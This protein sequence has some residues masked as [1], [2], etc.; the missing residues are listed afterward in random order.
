MARRGGARAV[1]LGALAAAGVAAAQLGLA[2]GLGIL[3]WVSQ[4]KGQAAA[5]GAWTAGLA[6]ATWL[7]ATSVV[8]GAVIGDRVRGSVENGPIVRAARRIIMALA[9]GLGAVLA[10]PLVAVP[11]SKLP[12]NDNYAPHLLVGIYV[13]SGV[14]LGLVVALFAMASRAIAAN[15]FATA[16]WLWVLAMVAVGDSTVR[17]G[18]DYAQLAVWKFTDAGPVWSGYYIPGALLML[19]AAFLV[20]GLTALP[21]AIRGAGRVGIAIA[22]AFGP[23]LVAVAYALAAP[24]SGNAPEE[25]VS[26]YHA[27]PYMVLAGLLGSTLVAVVGGFGRAKSRRSAPAATASV[28]QQATVTAEAP[29]PAAPAM[30]PRRLNGADEKAGLYGSRASV[31]ER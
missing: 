11:A 29:A 7:F 17:H 30:T 8:A 1:L 28:P 16:G 24:R 12:I 3:M 14:V 23:G 5:N 13:A 25:Q 22:G 4:A 26:A 18:L 21:A 27:A 9:A 6:W 31:V 2:Y 15:V 19:G 10:A 20:G